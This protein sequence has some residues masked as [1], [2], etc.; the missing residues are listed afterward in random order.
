MLPSFPLH[1]LH[2][3]SD[4]V[5]QSDSSPIFFHYLLYL[6]LIAYSEQWTVPPDS[7]SLKEKI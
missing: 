7:W 6:L 3:G 1:L 5:P 4:F 2:S